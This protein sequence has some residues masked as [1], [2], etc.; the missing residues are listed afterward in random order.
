MGAVIGDAPGPGM[1]VPIL[2][3]TAGGLADGKLFRGHHIF[4]INGQS[5]KG[6]SK[7]DAHTAIKE[8][9]VVKFTVS[10]V[11]SITG[12]EINY[13]GIQF[14][15]GRATNHHQTGDMYN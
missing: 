5:A 3:V 1:P 4:A 10:A 6:M 14:L 15:Q 12:D 11:A 7:R 2:E 8:C 9:Y 13:G